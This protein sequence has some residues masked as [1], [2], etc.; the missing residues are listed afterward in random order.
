MNEIYRC[1]RCGQHV[2]GWN[3]A[4]WWYN[5]PCVDGRPIHDWEYLAPDPEQAVTC[6]H[7]RAE[8]LVPGE[9]LDDET[10][11]CPNCG[12]PVV[13][14]G[15]VRLDKPELR[16]FVWDDGEGL[17]VAIAHSEEEARAIK[18]TWTSPDGN[19]IVTGTIGREAE[20]L[21]GNQ[22]PKVFEIGVMAFSYVE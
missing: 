7:C 4:H 10:I 14:N 2:Q 1:R 21:G 12:K 18:T 15:E 20:S 3:A 16:V 22:T 11:E 19:S 17:V 13:L 8:F 5:G 6:E 9:K